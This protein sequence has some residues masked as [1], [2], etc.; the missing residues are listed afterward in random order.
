MAGGRQ[1]IPIICS[2]WAVAR[3]LDNNWTL[4]GRD[5][6]NLM[7]PKDGSGQSAAKTRCR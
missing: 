4:I 3:K 6:L 5:Y 1:P 2:R 7:D